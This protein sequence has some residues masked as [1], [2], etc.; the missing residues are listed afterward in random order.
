MLRVYMGQERK[1][2]GFGL[3]SASSAAEGDGRLAILV[4][5]AAY[6]QKTSDVF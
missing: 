4:V 1:I 6:L 5:L 2:L 3:H